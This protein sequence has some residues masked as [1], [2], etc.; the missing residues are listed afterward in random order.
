MT[1]EQRRTS[2]IERFFF[3]ILR[4]LSAGVF[5]SVHDHRPA[6]Y[7]YTYNEGKFAV[8]FDPIMLSL[9]F[10]Q[11]LETAGA[12]I[13]LLWKNTQQNTTHLIIPCSSTR[14]YSSHFPPLL[15]SG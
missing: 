8:P 2:R 13:R 12:E 4:V 3:P 10:V 7:I 5:G 11:L 15:T 14:I 9:P 6:D 1:E